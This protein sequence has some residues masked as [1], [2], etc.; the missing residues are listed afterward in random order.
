MG[1][2]RKASR[3]NGMRLSLRNAEPSDA[4]F[5]LSLRTDPKLN[6]HIS[7][8]SGELAQQKSFLERYSNSDDEAFF[9]IEDR[10][11]CAHGT[12]R[13]Y[14]PQGDS[15]CW[16]SW[17]VRPDAP[18]RTGTRSAL[19]LYMYGF[20]YLGFG[21]S[22][23]DVRVENTAVWQFHERCGAELTEQTDLDRYY[24]LPRAAWDRMKVHY[25]SLIRN[26]G[27]SV[28]ELI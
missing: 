6:Q 18:P 27:F 4:A 9:I 17:I 13:M 10:E 25:N 22:H 3:I 5:I 19:L 1:L 28:E 21:A 26:A 2:I 23:F 8:V 15:F 14:D 12:I 16:G 20:D 24:T 11:G 7:R